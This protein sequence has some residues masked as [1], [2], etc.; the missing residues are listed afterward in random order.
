M[1]LAEKD[2][3]IA[4]SAY[5]PTL[6]A[7]I[8]YNTRESDRSSGIESIIDNDNPIT[9]T[10]EPIGVVDGSGEAVLDHSLTS[11]G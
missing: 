9:L 8:N 3:Q 10:D 6:N 1:D 4:R 11:L 5:Y 2:L 7:F